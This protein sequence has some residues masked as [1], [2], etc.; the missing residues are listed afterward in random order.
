MTR[1]ESLKKVVDGLNSNIYITNADRI[2]LM[3]E[4]I[5]ISLAI[6]ADALTEEGEAE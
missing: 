3:L 6:I 5:A 4:Q 2:G 1:V